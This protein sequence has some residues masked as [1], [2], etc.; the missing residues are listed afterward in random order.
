MSFESATLQIHAL[1]EESA[2]DNLETSSWGGFNDLGPIAQRGLYLY[3]ATQMNQILEEWL[4]PS[5]QW[6]LIASYVNYFN[7]VLSVWE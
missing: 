3:T 7:S 4:T 5:M 1:Q 6:N 2:T